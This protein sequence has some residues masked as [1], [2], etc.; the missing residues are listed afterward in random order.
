M[1]K[2]K[3]IVAGTRSFKDYAL[4]KEKLD[5]YLSH[6]PSESLEIVSGKAKGADS[7]GEQYATEN[8]ISIAE[9]PADWDSYGKR[10]G[11]LRNEQMAEYADCL[12]AFWNGK[13]VGTRHMIDLARKHGLKVRIVKY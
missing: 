3:V 9:F 7:L 8:E 6:Y 5:L 2:L 12:V 13:S 4:L 11:Y 10:A 1:E